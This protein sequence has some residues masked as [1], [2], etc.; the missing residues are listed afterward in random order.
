MTTRPTP[1]RRE[2]TRERPAVEPERHCHLVLLDDDQ[3]TYDYVIEMLG[4][5]FGYGV[6][7]AFALARI[8]DTEGRVILET[9][10]RAQCERHQSQIHAYGPDPKI[11]TC[12][13]SMSAVIEEAA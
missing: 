12:R 5:I 10:S 13:G 1:T 7:K 8:V 9:A 6:E 3:H 11:A 4:A 2:T